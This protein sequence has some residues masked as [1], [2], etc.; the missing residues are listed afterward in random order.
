MQAAYSL[1]GSIAMR[2]P[3]AAPVAVSARTMTAPP[4]PKAAVKSAA[5]STMAKSHPPGAALA[6]GWPGPVAV[7]DASNP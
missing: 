1:D 4:N 2:S 5:A 6:A 3:G 7:A